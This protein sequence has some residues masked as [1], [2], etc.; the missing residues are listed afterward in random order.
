[1]IDDDAHEGMLKKIKSKNI[2]SVV[3]TIVSYTLLIVTVVLV[4]LVGL[5]GAEEAPRNLGGFTVVRMTTNV[6]EPEVPMHS[7]ILNRPIDG[8]ENEVS[9][10]D[11]LTYL[12]DMDENIAIGRVVEILPNQHNGLPG[13]AF[14]HQDELNREVT[15]AQNVVGTSIFTNR[16]LGSVIMVFQYHLILTVSGAVFVF[17]ALL[18]LQAKLKGDVADMREKLGM[19]TI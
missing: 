5:Q 19:K 11:V 13:F 15:I 9:V 17:V 3:L 6:L 18:V 8:R 1:M 12:V 14:E 16:P 4:L 2:I 10:G 7:F